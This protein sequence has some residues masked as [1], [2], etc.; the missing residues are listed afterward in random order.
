MFYLISTVL[1]PPPKFRF[2]A[3]KCVEIPHGITGFCGAHSGIHCFCALHDYLEQLNS[4]DLGDNVTDS[5][6]QLIHIPELI[7][8][9]TTEPTKIKPKKG[10][11]KSQ[12]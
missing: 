8:I 3:M 2:V 6:S 12:I 11:S 7:V 9:I 10:N 5:I 1:L 4:N